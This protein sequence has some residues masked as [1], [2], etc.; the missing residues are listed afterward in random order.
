[1]KITIF[2][3]SKKIYESENA[4]YIELPG[5][6]GYMGILPGHE[7]LIT[8]LEIGEI[9]ISENGTNRYIAILGGVAKV[10]ND[11]VYILSDEAHLSDEL[12]NKE[13]EEAIQR[14]QKQLEQDLQPAELIRLEKEIKYHKLRKK[15]SSM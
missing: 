12:V 6:E 5:S 11:D 9:K 13:I 2:S 8:T 4:S 3:S 15:I 10:S 7:A 14:T 1:M